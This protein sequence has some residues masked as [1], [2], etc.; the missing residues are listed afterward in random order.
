[1]SE[2]AGWGIHKPLSDTDIVVEGWAG[3]YARLSDAEI[4]AILA[5]DQAPPKEAGIGNRTGYNGKGEHRC[6]NCGVRGHNRRACT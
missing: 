2:Y 4:D 3:A 5:G 6:G 1:M